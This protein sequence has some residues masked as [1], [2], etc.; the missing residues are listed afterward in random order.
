MSE[1][2][3]SLV[4]V[5]PKKE[6]KEGAVLHAGTESDGVLW[7]ALDSMEARP[8]VRHGS[9]SPFVNSTFD[10]VMFQPPYLLMFATAGEDGRPFW[11]VSLHCSWN[12]SRDRNDVSMEMGFA[13][14]PRW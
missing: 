1:T 4:W 13:G 9:N 3:T 10:G 12:R 8:I 11:N 5:M 6:G 7:G 2:C 14:S